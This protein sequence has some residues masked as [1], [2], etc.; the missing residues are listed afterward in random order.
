M[1]GIEIGA[2]N[3]GDLA[4]LPELGKP[5]GDL[6]LPVNLVVPPVEL[7]QIE[8]FQ[9]KPRQRGFNTLRNIG[10][11]QRFELAEIRHEFGVH[12]DPVQRLGTPDSFVLLP[13]STNQRFHAGVNIGAIKRRNPGVGKGNHVLDPGLPVDFAMPARQLPTALD[14]ARDPVPRRE[15]KCLHCHLPKARRLSRNG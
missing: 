4:L 10:P 7:N 2:A 11:R 15:V 6:D 12:L 13:E 1:L 9:P 14:N 8:L 3:I 5:G